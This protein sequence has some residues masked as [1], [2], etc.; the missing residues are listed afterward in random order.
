MMKKRESE[1]GSEVA[2]RDE[3]HGR[4]ES[5]ARV[6]EEEDDGYWYQLGWIEPRWQ[7]DSEEKIKYNL[8]IKSY[9]P[10]Q[11]AASSKR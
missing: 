2:A 5:D 10:V 3:Q 11:E 1:F 4:K 6:D 7:E 8:E 9:L